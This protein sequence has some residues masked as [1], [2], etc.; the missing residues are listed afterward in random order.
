MH[1]VD[2]KNALLAFNSLLDILHVKAFGYGVGTH[3]QAFGQQTPS[4]EEDDHSNNEAD[5]GVDN[6]PAS[7]INNHTA[8]NDAYTDQRVGQHVEEGTASVDVVLLLTAESPCGETVDDDA[9]SGSPDDEGAI[10]IGRVHKFAYALD[11]DGADGDEEN[12]GVEERDKH[13]GLAVAVGKAS[14][15]AAG[16]Q[17]E[18][19]HGQQEREDVAEVVSGIGE[20]A[21]RVPD[22]TGDGFDD[23]ECQIER[24]RYYIYCRQLLNGV[25]MVVMVMTVIIMIVMVMFVLR[26]RSGDFMMV[27]M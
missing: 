10:D 26:R 22:K 7:E 3:A 14:S 23:D 11:H 25:C 2:I 19:H 13:G 9:H 20:Q 16:G 27:V 1:V 18:G 5:D 15:G 21:Q 6:G 17:L 8:D 4:A 12:D 24:Y